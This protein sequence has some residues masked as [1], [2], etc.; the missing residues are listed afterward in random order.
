MPKEEKI[1]EYLRFGQII[2]I[3]G[4]KC[5]QT[6]N[7]KEE[8]RGMIT[9]KGFTDKDAKYTTFLSFRNCEFYRQS[10]F[11]I[12]PRG[13]FEKADTPEEE[14]RKIKEYL[15]LVDRYAP[16]H[17]AKQ[18]RKSSSEKTSS[19]SMSTPTTTSQAQSAARTEDWEP[20]RW[21]WCQASVQIWYLNYS[22]S[23]HS[24]N[25]ATKSS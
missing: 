25:R 22:P 1:E 16:P 15:A 14:D 18:D 4:H 10:L 11:Q 17:S 13:Q 12:L 8:I 21:S 2:R 19:S 9:V 7:D 6:D 20:S 24:K 3:H 5:L 23:A